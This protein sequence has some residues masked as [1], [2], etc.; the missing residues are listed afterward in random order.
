MS[1]GSRLLC[2]IVVD[3]GYYWNHRLPVPAFASPY[4]S[5]SPRMDV[6]VTSRN[7][8]WTS[9]FILSLGKRS[10]H[11][12]HRTLGDGCLGITLTAA[13]AFGVTWPAACGLYR[14]LALSD[15]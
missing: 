5:S 13:P 8:L 12:P 7:T 9:L 10:S 11:L 14:V 1:L 2:F 15:Y 3:Y 6:W 4:P